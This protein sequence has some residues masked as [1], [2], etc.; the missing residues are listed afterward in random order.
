MSGVEDCFYH[1]AIATGNPGSKERH[2]APAISQ[3]HSA[4]IPSFYA[5]FSNFICFCV[6]F[7]NPFMFRRNSFSFAPTNALQIP[8]WGSDINA[9]APT[10]V[11]GRRMGLFEHDSDYV[12][13]A[14][15]GGR[16]N[17]LSHPESAHR[18]NK[19]IN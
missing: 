3:V 8:G 18:A 9:T 2:A 12:R 7:S 5:S 6:C 15:M 11:G 4:A 13:L 16:A 17:L 19:V 1:E 14:K 10:P